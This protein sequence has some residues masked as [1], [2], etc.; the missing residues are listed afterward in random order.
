MMVDFMCWLGHKVP[1]NLVKQYSGV[2]PKMF[3]GEINILIGEV[4]CPLWS[5]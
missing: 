4:D 2:F 5:M 3:L 1:D